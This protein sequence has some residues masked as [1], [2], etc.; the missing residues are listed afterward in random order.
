MEKSE[1]DYW[2]DS[3]TVKYSKK[4]NMFDDDVTI[5]KASEMALYRKNLASDGVEEEEEGI[6]WNDDPSP[7]LSNSIVTSA[8]PAKPS[9]D[10][11]I[12]VSKSIVTPTEPAKPSSDS[13]IKASASGGSSFP[14]KTLDPG[15]GAPTRT[16]SSPMTHARSRSE[17]IVGKGTL[18]LPE[19]PALA[20]FS[21]DREPSLAT[22]ISRNQPAVKPSIGPQ[23]ISQKDDQIRYLQQQLDNAL[24]VTKLKVDDTVK[25]MLRG[26]PYSLEA[27]K[28][29]EEKLELLDKA[30]ATHDGNAITAVVVFLKRTLKDQLFNLELMRRPVA[31]EQYLAYLRAHYNTHEYEHMLQ[32][33]GR[34]EEQAMLKYKHAASLADPNAKI[35]RLTACQQAH[36][37]CSPGLESDGSL[38]VQ[39]IN[40]LRRQLPVDA[41]D[42]E[43][44]KTGKA[45]VFQQHPRATSIINMPVITT[46]Y[47]CC[48]YHYGESENLLGSPEDIRKKHQLTEKQFVWTT[49][50]ARAKLHKWDDVET[51]FTT[52]NWLGNT[53]MKSVI[54]FEKVCQ[55]LNQ[56]GTPPDILKKFFRNIDD[57]DRRLELANKLQCHDA[58]IE[59]YQ[60]RGNRSALQAYFDK[61]KPQSREWFLAGGVLKDQ[62]IKWKT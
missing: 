43:T 31:V 10:T 11:G 45:L 39:Q 55:V 59:T 7:S 44:E 60:Q 56:Q 8:E 58:I 52:K 29:K 37:A 24:G 25:R 18:S 1:D 42:E 13:G 16:Q 32:L 5:E 53:K 46:L 33:L 62:N 38:I 30:I 47:Y 3:N 36:F 48:V 61:L 20:H 21:Q 41:A 12:R 6:G 9:S 27:Y 49:L 14:R 28:G 40:M 54:G 51:L 15:P 17:V 57:V 23:S 4:K 22:M 50:R 34:T 2:G 19:V 35:D 26:Q